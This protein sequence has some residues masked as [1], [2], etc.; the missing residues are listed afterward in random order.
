MHVCSPSIKS[1]YT[2]DFRQLRV[3]GFSLQAPCILMSASAPRKDF[4]QGDEFP[5]PYFLSS[6][7]LSSSRLLSSIQH[8]TPHYTTLHFIKLHYTTTTHSR[9]QN[10][11]PDCTTRHYNTLYYTYTTLLHYTTLHCVYTRLHYTHSSHVLSHLTSLL[12]TS[13]HIIPRLLHLNCF[14]LHYITRICSDLQL[15]LFHRTYASLKLHCSSSHL[16]SDHR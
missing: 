10:T 9:L 3:Y 5:S 15:M 1:K 6:I 16:F 2:A 12:P 8:T 4:L 7:L 14:A 11:T 13:Y